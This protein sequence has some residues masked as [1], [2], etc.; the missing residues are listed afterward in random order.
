M[1]GLLLSEPQVCCWA[2]GILSNFFFLY[3]SHDFSAPAHCW[4]KTCLQGAASWKNLI[5]WEF[6][7]V[8]FCVQYIRIWAVLYINVPSVYGCEQGRRNLWLGHWLKLALVFS[9]PYRI[10]IKQCIYMQNTLP[11][12]G[13][14]ERALVGILGSHSFCSNSADGQRAFTETLAY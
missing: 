4:Q 3:S 2:I 8:S 5:T 7:V 14:D 1:S 9:I 6:F 10:C 13:N 11:W 12:S